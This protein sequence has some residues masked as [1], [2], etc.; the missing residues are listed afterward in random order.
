M[1]KFSD[2]IE[3]IDSAETNFRVFRENI[4]IEQYEKLSYL[5]TD[6]FELKDIDILAIILILEKCNKCLAHSNYI[7]L[8]DVLAFE[9]RPQLLMEMARSN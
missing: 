8:A 6:F 2:L 1:E 9:L 4:G 3:V 5:L 7:G